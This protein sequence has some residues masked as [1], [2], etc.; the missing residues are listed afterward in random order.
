[1]RHS[2]VENVLPLSLYSGSNSK[3]SATIF[4]L[5]MT[6]ARCAGAVGSISAASGVPFTLEAIWSG[7]DIHF[8]RSL[9]SDLYLSRWARI[10]RGP[11]VKKAFSYSLSGRN[12]AAIVIAVSSL[13]SSLA[14][15]Q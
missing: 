14:S 15:D 2:A 5:E 11:S 1:M 9:E 3:L 6:P 12:A 7:S 4:R 13:R 10:L 8:K